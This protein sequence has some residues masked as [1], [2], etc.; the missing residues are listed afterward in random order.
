MVPV[1]PSV[2]L[3][4][5]VGYNNRAAFLLF[6]LGSLLFA[7]LCRKRFAEPESIDQP[8]GLASLLMALFIAIIC[9][10]WRLLPAD[11]H[12]IGGEAAYT[13]NRIQMLLQGLRPYR[14]FEF[15]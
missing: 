14:D 4:Y 10:A 12:Q 2:S 15:A 9:C 1:A 13:L 5:V 7:V 6:S 8:L 11:R 3:S